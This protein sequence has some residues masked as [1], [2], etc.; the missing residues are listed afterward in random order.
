MAIST[1]SVFRSGVWF[2][3]RPK[4]RAG[5]AAHDPC[6]PVGDPLSILAACF[7]RAEAGDL[8]MKVNERS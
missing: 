6:G 8:V 4:L 7:T 2:R 1:S 3:N 5:D